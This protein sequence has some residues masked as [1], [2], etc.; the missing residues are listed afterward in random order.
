MKDSPPE[1]EKGTLPGASLADLD[2]VLTDGGIV[3]QSGAKVKPVVGAGF[4]NGE[5]VP[6]VL[7]SSD[8]PEPRELTPLSAIGRVF[9]A[10]LDHAIGKRTL[11]SCAV[12][13]ALRQDC[14]T[15]RE[16]ADEFGVTPHAVRKAIR[17]ANAVLESEVK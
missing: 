17:E 4:E 5:L 13:V 11:K 14:R 2:L 7:H 6:T 8:Q 15:P 12:M 3:N 1:N 9:I 16:I 10:L